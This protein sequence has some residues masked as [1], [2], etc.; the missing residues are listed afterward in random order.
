MIYCEP[1]RAVKRLSLYQAYCPNIKAVDAMKC[2]IANMTKKAP[3]DLKV[4]M[5]IAPTDI[6]RKIYFFEEE[7]NRIIAAMG[8]P[9]AP[10]ELETIDSAPLYAVKAMTLGKLLYP[11][12][13]EQIAEDVI[14]DMLDSKWLKDFPEN[15]GCLTKNKLVSIEIALLI[16]NR[17]NRLDVIGKVCEKTINVV[18]FADDPGKV[19]WEGSDKFYKR[20]FASMYYPKVA[21]ARAQQNLYQVIKRNEELDKLLT[22]ME[23]SSRKQYWT[24]EQVRTIFLYLGTPDNPKFS[25]NN[26]KPKAV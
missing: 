3:E 5:H 20:E 24:R 16:C 17:L 15:L 26:I 2:F 9:I 13:E 23:P 11:K 22:K 12:K 4:L 14:M 25:L 21:P 18:L 6:I 1:T 10:I 19:N 7:V 8:K